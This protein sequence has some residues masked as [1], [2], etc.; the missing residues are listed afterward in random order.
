MSSNIKNDVININ[1][2]MD[3]DNMNL[4]KVYTV[5]LYMIYKRKLMDTGIYQWPA[6]LCF[7]T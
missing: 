7:N 3:N 6:E 2:E 4:V 1:T 5:F